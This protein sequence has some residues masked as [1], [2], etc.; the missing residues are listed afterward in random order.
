MLLPTQDRKQSEPQASTPPPPEP[1]AA[2]HVATSYL[3]WALERVKDFTSDNEDDEPMF[4]K[5]VLT[6][7]TFSSHQ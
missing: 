3:D 5:T 4:S 1:A 2:P 6:Q 7:D